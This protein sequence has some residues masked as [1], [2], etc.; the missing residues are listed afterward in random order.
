MD[1]EQVYNDRLR[2]LEVAY[3]EGYLAH[4]LDFAFHEHEYDNS[5]LEASAWRFGWNDRAL[6]KPLGP[7]AET[8]AYLRSLIVQAVNPYLEEAQF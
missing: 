4:K 6:E 5:T 3:N 1:Y 8:R 2:K 7:D